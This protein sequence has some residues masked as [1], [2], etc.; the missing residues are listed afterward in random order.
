MTKVFASGTGMPIGT[1]S[2]YHDESKISY[3]SNNQE[4][5]DGVKF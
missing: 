5:F 3:S 4:N 1:C 2:C